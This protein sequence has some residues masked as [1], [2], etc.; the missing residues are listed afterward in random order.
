MPRAGAG[1]RRTGGVAALAL[2][3]LAAAAPSDAQ[4]LS[5]VAL[6][7][8]GEPLADYPVVLH[9]VGG[10]GGAFVGT[11]TTGP[12]G[13]FRFIL[14]SPDSAVYFAAVRFEGRMYI[15]PAVQ[16]GGTEPI[17]GYA[18]RVEPGAEAGAVASALSGPTA[19]PQAALPATGTGRGA[20]SDTGAYL[21]VGLLAL[22]AAAAYL[23]AA[24]RY[25]RQRTREAVIEL[26][27]LENRLADADP[28]DRD[29]LATERDRQRER[30]APRS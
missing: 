18:L 2:A 14:E 15:G 30:L 20:G 10:G 13:A 11:D 1:L 3:L 22:A 12:D 29:R 9:R 6:A 8:G 17:T 19:A 5:G 27:R 21:L 25:R 23:F 7:P 4:G 26:A 24:P 16:G 28:T